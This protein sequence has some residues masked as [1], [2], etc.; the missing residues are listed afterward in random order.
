LAYAD[1]FWMSGSRGVP[2]HVDADAAPGT[3]IEQLTHR[4][5]V[6][7]TV[8]FHSFLRIS[9]GDGT[10]LTPNTFDGL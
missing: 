10:F 6:S 2:F 8:P 7:G 1:D 3:R 9:Y 5:N 4:R